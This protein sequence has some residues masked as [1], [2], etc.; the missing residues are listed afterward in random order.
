MKKVFK[1]FALSILAL[2]FSGCL[3]DDNNNIIYFYDEPAVVESL[4]ENPII[5]SSHDRFVVNLPSELEVGEL[6]FTS[7]TVNRDKKK[8]LDGKDYYQADEFRFLKVDSSEVII[9]ENVAAFESYLSDDYTAFIDEAGLYRDYLDNFLFFNF[10]RKNSSENKLL[11][12]EMVLNPEIENPNNGYPTLYIRSKKTETSADSSGQGT[13][14]AFDMTK[15]IAYYLTNIADK[16]VIGFNIKYK[17]GV[18]EEGKDIYRAFIS[19]PITWQI[20]VNPK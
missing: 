16:D 20:Q 3:K 8:T 12:Y 13:V 2:A 17:I 5:R 18:D 4:G 11:D 9:P 1:F 7:F 10:K 14:F 19:N 6:L 15:F